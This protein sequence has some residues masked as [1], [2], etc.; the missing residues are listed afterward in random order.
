VTDADRDELR[1]WL[2]DSYGPLTAELRKIQS[3]LKASE[4]NARTEAG[5]RS[6]RRDAGADF[7][8]LA[9]RFEEARNRL[10]EGALDEETA[11]MLRVWAGS[12]YTYCVM[13][14]QYLSGNQMSRPVQP[15]T[16]LLAQANRAFERALPILRE[17]L[18]DQP[19]ETQQPAT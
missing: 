14:A 1:A 9:R 5:R 13:R 16:R 2:A 15:L 7:S 18:D 8:V 10:P 4:E 17:L 3:G 12:L 19:A 11:Q 6:I